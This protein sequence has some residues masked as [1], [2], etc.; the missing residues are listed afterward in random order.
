MTL[1]RKAY[2]VI[3]Y[4]K[5]AYFLRKGIFGSNSPAAV[6]KLISEFVMLE[7]PFYSNKIVMGR[8]MNKSIQ[9]FR[10][11]VNSYTETK[12]DVTLDQILEVLKEEILKREDK[13]HGR[14]Q[15]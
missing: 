6:L 13:R 12:S 5:F 8:T 7:A 15:F 3:N 4:L 11:L 1:K 2:S 14:K 9:L 10:T